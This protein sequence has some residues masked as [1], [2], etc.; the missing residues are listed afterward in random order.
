MNASLENGMRCLN[1]RCRNEIGQGEGF[2]ATF[3][4]LVAHPS[5]SIEQGFLCSP[6]LRY[7]KRVGLSKRLGQNRDWFFVENGRFEIRLGV[8]QEV[9]ERY[10]P[11]LFGLW[12]GRGW[13]REPD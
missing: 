2:L 6:C 13:Y 10:F 5:P 7:L 8:T 4:P 12:T 3:H 9:D 11:Y 1:S